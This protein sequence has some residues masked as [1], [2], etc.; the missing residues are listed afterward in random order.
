MSEEIE[1]IRNFCKS[2]TKELWNKLSQNTK[3]KMIKLSFECIDKNIGKINLAH[4][5]VKILENKNIVYK[6]GK[7]I[8]VITSDKSMYIMSSDNK[9]FQTMM[10]HSIPAWDK[11][12][13]NNHIKKIYMGKQINTTIGPRL[14]LTFRYYG[15][16]QPKFEDKKYYELEKV[17]YNDCISV[18]VINNVGFS[19]NNVYNL[20]KL[21]LKPDIAKMF[22]KIYTNNGRLVATY[23][24][25]KNLKLYNY[26]GKSVKINLMNGDMQKILERIQKL[27]NLQ[28]NWVH[29]VY[30][31]FGE[32]KL[33]WHSDMTPELAYSSSIAGIS[34]F[35]NNNDIRSVEFKNGK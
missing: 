34:L 31:P 17:W 13:I 29:V 2:Q 6:R 1:K 26:G 10:K 3:N 30:Y 5:I 24:T 23:T 9:C 20:V 25:D 14:S 7:R 18:R 16:K 19:F 8:G 4:K 28:F 12:L 11:T 32:T 21:D 15:E 27:C 33:D 22:N 35:K